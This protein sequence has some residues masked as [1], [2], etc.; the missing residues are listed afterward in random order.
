MQGVPAGQYQVVWRMMKDR[1]GDAGFGSSRMSLSVHGRRVHLSSTKCN[2]T[3]D[4]FT[5][6]MQHFKSLPANQWH[7]VCGG[8]IE[9]SDFSNIRTRLWN[10]S[11]YHSKHSLAWDSVRLVSMH[12]PVAAELL[13]HSSRSVQTAVSGTT[14][15]I[16]QA[17]AS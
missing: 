8:R 13:E 17:A 12:E 10:H 16:A 11:D 15:P 9:V 7:D 5:Y 3:D 4:D 2:E 14:V 1:E 6:P